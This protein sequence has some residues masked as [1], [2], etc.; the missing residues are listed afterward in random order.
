MHGIMVLWIRRTNVYLNEIRNILFL[1]CFGLGG[2]FCYNSSCFDIKVKW[3]QERNW[4]L[5]MFREHTRDLRVAFNKALHKVHMVFNNSL[6][7]SSVVFP[8]SYNVD[9]S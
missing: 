6:S 8:T 9:D 4:V 5:T 1:L 2:F 7:S 3:S